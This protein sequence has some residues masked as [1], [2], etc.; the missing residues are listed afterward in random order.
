MRQQEYTVSDSVV[1]VTVKCA[2]Q[3]HNT[4]V[5]MPPGLAS[6]SGAQVIPQP[7]QAPAYTGANPDHFMENRFYSPILRAADQ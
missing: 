3:Q 1:I 7:N 2:C 6:E 4:Y 5:F